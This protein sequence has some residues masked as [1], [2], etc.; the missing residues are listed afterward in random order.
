MFVRVRQLW[1]A[2]A[3]VPVLLFT[4]FPGASAQIRK[5]SGDPLS[6][7][8]FTSPKLSLTQPIVPYDQV[9]AQLA[10]DVSGPWQKFHRERIR[11]AASVDRRNGAIAFASGDGIPWIGKGEEENVNTRTLEKIARELLGSVGSFLRV[12]PHSLVLDKGRSMKASPHVWFIEFDVLAGDTPIEGAH[13]IFRVNHGNLIQFG[14]EYLPSPGAN[15]PPAKLERAQALAVTEKYIGGFHDSDKFLDLGSLHLIPIDLTASEATGGPVAVPGPPPNIA[16]VPGRSM[17]PIPFSFGEGR[18]LARVWQFVFHRPGI[19]GTFQARIDAT[20]GELLEFRDI[21]E[22]T[23]AQATGGVYANS[24][25]TGPEIVRPFPFLDLSTG[26]FSNSAGLYNF[27]GGTLTSAMNG[28]YIKIHDGNCGTGTISLTADGSGY[29][30][31]GTSAGTNC[32]TPGFGGDG[33]THAAR[34]QFYQTNRAMEIARGW[35]PANVW[36][37]NQLTINVNLTGTC[38]AF[39]SPGAGNLNFFQ[40][41][42]GCANTG[43]ISGATI[44]EFGHGLDQNDG[45]GSSPDSGT[46]EAVADITS[47]MVLHNSC[48]GPGLFSTNCTGYGDACTS[49]TG[50]R[51]VDWAKHASNTPATVSNFS[52]VD[53]QIGGGGMCGGEGHCE[54]RVATE[55]V[56]DFVNRDLPQPGSDAAWNTGER[57]FFTSRP[58][59]TAAFTCTS[60]G[61]TWTS[62][63]CNAGSLWEIFRALDDDDGNLANGTPHGGALFS[64]FDRHGIA[65]ATDPGASTTSTGCTPPETPAVTV[66]GGTNQVTVS[67][68]AVP[69]VIYDVYRSE[70]GC[71]HGFAKIAP[72]STSPYTDTAV[73]NG[74]NYSYQVVAYP[75]GN[76][77]C[78]AIP[79]SC[80]SANLVGPDPSIRPWGAALNPP[81]QPFW[82][83]PDIWVDNNG[84]G[85]PNEMT[86]PT[87]NKPDNQLFARVTNTGN[88]PTSGFRVSF[89]G[90]PYTTNASAP[91]QAIDFVDEPGPVAAG[92]SNNYKVTWDLTAAWVHNFDQMFWTADHFCVQVTIGP[93]TGAFNDSDLTNN[94][95]QNNFDNIPVAFGFRSASAHFFLYNHLDHAAIASLE[96]VSHT[97]GWSVKFEKIAD[98]KN[99][100]M[101]PKQWIEVVAVL[102][103]QPGAPHPTETAPIFID[104]SQQLEGKTVGGLTFALKPPVGGGTTPPPVAGRLAVFADLGA[105]IPHG[106]FSNAFNPGVSFNAGLEYI[107]N[108]HLSAEGILGV[109]HFG[110]K[111]TGDLNVIQFT[112]GGKVYFNTASTPNRVF[113][114]GGLGGYHFTV[115][116]STNFGGYVG[117]GLLHNFNAHWGVEGV[118][119]FHSVNTPGAASKFSTIQ[120]GI[121]YAF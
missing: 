18:G 40:T 36:L 15:A 59:G 50:I 8:E 88:A 84:N 52:Q 99:V 14:T 121:R 35:L 57:L 105:A 30:N 22:Y 69:G 37:T 91:A 55:A 62:N 118:Y 75:T 60:S 4:A 82:Q 29:L 7:L 87:L 81:Q 32:T 78:S 96:G 108:P 31:F 83:T 97:P 107:V 49:C 74:T 24:A 89:A 103:A 48:I 9:A 102:T 1:I 20:T 70:A 67:W 114:R 19:V 34:E 10:P 54:S 119:T 13:V 100:S 21:N 3:V 112:G 61:V 68:T 11:W 51:E 94:F 113:L 109:H 2:L 64:A 110:G 33:N 66:T 117:A 92:A 12:D 42:S 27:T 45:N 76:P 6:K 115:G 65:C 98:P 111:V 86:E 90:K 46:R 79:S 5:P 106:T 43:E 53:C 38:N 77:A 17:R 58:T 25:A 72:G 80:T 44:H 120:G 39:W 26:G 71:N 95:A 56:W 85:I 41:F 116:S 104:V 16:L 28:Q 101:Q 73:A 63:G 23:Q 47:F 93:S